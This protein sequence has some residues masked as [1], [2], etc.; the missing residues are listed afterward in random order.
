MR[1]AAELA[2]TTDGPEGRQAERA[3]VKLAAAA[4]RQG[5]HGYAIKLL[6]ISTRGCRI[7]TASL[8]HAG[9]NIWLKLPG[10]E[11]I[12]ARV[13]WVRG[14]RAGCQFATPLHPAVVDRIVASAGRQS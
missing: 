3:E 10:L 5:G 11:A 13:A 14:V 12:Y 8:L 1:L 7:E 9:T 4:R 6:D 2:V